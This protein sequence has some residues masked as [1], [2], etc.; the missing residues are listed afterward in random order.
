ML[1][2]SNEELRVVAL[3]TLRFNV[4]VDFFTEEVQFDA[5]DSDEGLIAG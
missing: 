2:A 1:A 3:A 5:A 4:V